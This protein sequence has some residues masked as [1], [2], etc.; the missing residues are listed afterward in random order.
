[1]MLWSLILVPLAAAPMALWAERRSGDA[2]RW[3]AVVAMAIDL[4]LAL[5]LWTEDTGANAQT[6][7]DLTAADLERFVYDLG[8]NASVEGGKVPLA[9]GRWKD[10]A[11]GGS[12][13]TLL[14]QRAIGDLDGDGRADAAGIVVETTS[15]T[16]SFAY[17]FAL[18][19]RD[20][21]PV[22]AGPPEW[23]GDRSVIERL[24]I[25]RKGILSVRYVTHRDSDRECCPT[26]R[27]DDR[28]R[29]EGDTLVGITK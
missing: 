14:P 15:G 23:L 8:E 26:L 4:I 11:E 19:S 27:I 21:G 6:K 5:V 24:S 12:T 28:Y 9:G 17:L 3:I 1:M 13:F 18:L 10:P 7:P 2:P 25:D 22:Q 16:G 29:I 20:G